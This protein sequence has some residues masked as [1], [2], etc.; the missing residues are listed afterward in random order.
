MNSE[1][2]Q[3][4]IKMH[5]AVLLWGFTGVLGKAISVSEYP[6]VFY[7]VC[8]T[9]LFLWIILRFQKNLPPMP[10]RTKIIFIGIGA[11]IGIH[12]IT[13]F[14]SIKYSSPEIGLICLST[15]SIYL[16]IMEPIL[17]KKTPRLIDILCS[18][19][20]FLGVAIIAKG[21]YNYLL[22]ILMGLISAFLASVFSYL[23]KK[24]IQGQDSKRALY[25]EMIGSILFL[26]ICF[27]I[28]NSLFLQT[29]VI[30]SFKDILLL[31]GLAA[32]CTVLAQTLALEALKKISS[33]TAV[34]TVN[35]EPVYGI[36]I[37]YLIYK[38]ATILTL[39]FFIG[40]T[41]IMVALIAN[42]LGRKW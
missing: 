24:H 37:A 6:L 4:Y 19:C 22:G 41:L 3:A 34:L 25:F 9:A 26:L 7:R 33:F 16:A 13:F 20:V 28:Y 31:I 11:I 14:G 35:L 12:W 2:K 42:G 17:Q 29:I 5:I 27:P 10:K 30:P 8:L 36:I 1:Y 32:F 39:D 21:A 23:N 15:S 40:F 38:D 18:L